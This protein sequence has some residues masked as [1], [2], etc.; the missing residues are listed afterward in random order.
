MRINFNVSKNRKFYHKKNALTCIIT[1][2]FSH[3]QKLF[4]LYIK[5]KNKQQLSLLRD[6]DNVEWFVDIRRKVKIEDEKVMSSW[7]SV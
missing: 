5:T 2:T 7:K 6:W 3:K 1:K 4:P